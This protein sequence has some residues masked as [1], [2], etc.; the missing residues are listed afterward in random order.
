MHKHSTVKK[1][2]P[3]R[4]GWVLPAVCLIL[5]RML[6]ACSA[7]CPGP[8]YN[9]EQF[10]CTLGI[11]RTFT[12]D[13]TG[14]P[15]AFVMTITAPARLCGLTL[16]FTEGGCTLSAGE[17]SIPLSQGAA[18][19]LEQIVTLLTAHPDTALDCTPTETGAAY[20]DDLGWVRLDENG[21]PAEAETADGRHIR[22][23][24]FLSGPLETLA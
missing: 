5:C 4:R 3:A 12:A 8:A 18:V 2:A 7:A 21:L 13:C 20:R 10:T 15:D 17:A 24:G 1:A 19:S 14:T 9:P 6:T 11:D 23:T 22:I 16:T